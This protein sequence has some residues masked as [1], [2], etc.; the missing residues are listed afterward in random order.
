M[1]YFNSDQNLDKAY[2]SAFSEFKEDINQIK[3]YLTTANNQNML[4]KFEYWSVGYIM[5]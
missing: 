4:A 5:D 1:D 3:T 2:K